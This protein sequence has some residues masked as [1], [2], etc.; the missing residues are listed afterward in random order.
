MSNIV[1]TGAFDVFAEL[2]PHIAMIIYRIHNSNHLLLSRILYM[3][4]ALELVGTT[5]ETVIVMWLFGSLWDKWTLS[6]KI[7]TP[8]LHILFSAAQLW[9]AWIFYKMGKEQRLEYEKEALV[10]PM[11]EC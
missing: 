9:G 10:S 5:V 2:W 11:E 8:I 3:T 7:A 6:L 1:I 4:M